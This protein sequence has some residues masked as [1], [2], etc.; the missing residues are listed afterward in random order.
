MSNSAITWALSQKTGSPTSKLILFKLADQANDNGVCWPSQK[1]MAAQCECNRATV[2]RHIKKLEDKGFLEVMRRTKDG[3]SLLNLYK[4]SLCNENEGV[5][6]QSYR[7]GRTELQG[8]G[9]QSYRGGRTELQGVGA[10]SYTNPQLEPS[11]NPHSIAPSDKSLNADDQPD[12]LPAET[13]EPIAEHIPLNNDTEHPVTASQMDEYQRL[14]PAVDVP[15]ALRAMRGWCLAN[16]KKRKTKRGVKSFINAWLSKDQDKG[17]S[18]G[19]SNSANNAGR[20][21]SAAE[22]FWARREGQVFDNG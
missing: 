19:T 1:T 3:V 6:A 20:T 15:Q 18:N 8:V 4:L 9:A 7:G 10:Q 5:G 14:Y 16:P 12:Q 13:D 17:G 22:R 2:N 21:Q 11:V